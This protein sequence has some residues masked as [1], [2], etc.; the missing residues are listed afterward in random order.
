LLNHP[1][2]DC[3]F[4]SLAERLSRRVVTV[5]RR[6]LCAVRATAAAG[7]V[8]GNEEAAAGTGEA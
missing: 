8:L 2:H 1:A 4:L 3:L 5:D 6:F 7:L